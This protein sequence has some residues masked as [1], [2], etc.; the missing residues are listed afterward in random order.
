MEIARSS[1]RPAVSH[2]RWGL[3][4]LVLGAALLVAPFRAVRVVGSSMFPTLHDGQQVLV[5]RAYYRLT[6]LFRYDLVV[7]RHNGENW[8]KRLVGLPG[9]RLALA[10]GP[11]GGIDGVVNLQ[12][13]LTS[14]PSA[15]VVTVPPGQLY[16]VGDNLP[17]S[18]DSRTVGPIPLAELIGVVRSPTMGRVF[19]WPASR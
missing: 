16:I 2:W 8:V 10:Y 18:K 1:P 14:P 7:V 5:D 11:E 13:G 4:S 15:V 12:S 9:D 19:P 6:G 17:V 3:W